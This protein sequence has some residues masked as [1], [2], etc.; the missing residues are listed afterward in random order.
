MR[1]MPSTDRN[2]FC[3]KPTHN[4][5][6][7]LATFMLP[8]KSVDTKKAKTKK[9]H[10]GFGGFNFPALVKKKKDSF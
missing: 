8:R 2:K 9:A 10:N 7:F 1:S 6:V 3:K 5:S 4:D